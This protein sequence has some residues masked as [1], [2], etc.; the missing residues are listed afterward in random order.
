MM[1][2][3]LRADHVLLGSP[4]RK[5][6]L[7]EACEHPERNLQHIF[8]DLGRRRRRIEKKDTGG[9]D[10]VVGCCCCASLLEADGIVYGTH[11]RQ[12]AHRACNEEFNGRPKVDQVSHG[13]R[14]VVPLCAD[15][16]VRKMHSA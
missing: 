1:Y 8:Q 13:S 4:T 14:W 15:T 7:Q 3:L 12:D 16:K 6:T 9:F 10:L 2:I 5:G 11:S